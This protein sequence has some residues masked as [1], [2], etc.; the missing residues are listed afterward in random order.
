M[1]S[2]APRR[3]PASRAALARTLVL[4]L[5]VG[6][7]GGG[8]ACTCSKANESIADDAGA[9][10]SFDGSD[11]TN[12]A[13]GE[14]GGL[15]APIAAAR[16][17][18]GDVVVAGL[19][20]AA[21]AIRVQRISDKDELLVDQTIFDGVMWSSESELKVA[22]A[23]AGVAVTWRGLRAGKLVRQL[24]ILG[25]DLAPIGS[26]HDVSAA[27]CAT[28][29]AVWFTDG[30]R[31]HTRPWTGRPA[32]FDLPKDKDAVLVC[33]VHR[34]FA[35]LDEDDGTSLVTF[36][37]A[38]LASSAGGLDAGARPDARAG[39]GGGG[40]D[41]AAGAGAGVSRPMQL[42]TESEFGEDDQ[43]ERPDYTVGDDVGVV[44]L[45][46]SGAMALR[47][48]R[49]GIPGSLHKLRTVIPRDDDV[50]AVD[51]TPR[52]V[53]IVFS[54]DVSDACAKD[55]GTTATVGS[56]RVKALRVDRTTFEESIV[57]LSPGMCAREVGPFFTGAQGDG[58]SV[59]W[60]E[61]VP[62]A[63]K[64]R[65]PIAALA[66]C[67][68]PAAG[69]TAELARVEQA[70]D[71]LVDAACDGTRCYAVALARRAGM[72][73]MVPGLAKVIRY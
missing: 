21:R 23:A 29:D 42:L 69:P 19:D 67:V 51:A 20:V 11:E 54:E 26:V 34:A 5:L 56:T 66:H 43:R 37:G 17:E 28:R 12:A 38:S 58:V 68:V 41:A 59:A 40:G 72:D 48:V 8:S 10:S 22:P 36:G 60:V 4:A 24:V 14:P 18:H 33:G 1:A 49:D 9:V 2:R 6:L 31:V 7:A 64:S 35:L 46:V 39:G 52:V 63:G 70:A 55:G 16:G 30:R 3:A 62:I 45:G 57:E 25:A 53:V 47:E 73:A 13:G 61:R 32:R 27:S 50:V 15:S 71:A 44:R 65:A